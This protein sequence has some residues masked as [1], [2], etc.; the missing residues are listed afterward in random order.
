MRLGTAKDKPTERE[1]RVRSK[2]VRD[3]VEYLQLSILAF[4]FIKATQDDDD[5]FTRAPALKGGKWL[6]NEFAELNGRGIL[7]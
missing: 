2:S 5:W 3:H 4:A 6:N 1:I 7:Q